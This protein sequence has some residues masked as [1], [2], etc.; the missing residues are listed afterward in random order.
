MINLITSFF[1]YNEENEILKNRNK[2]LTNSLINN[3]NSEFIKKIHLFIENDNVLEIINKLEKKD[4]INIIFFK[5]QPLYSDFFEYSINNLENEI[6]MISNSDI[7]L[8]YCDL[9]CINN[10]SNNI[11]CLTRYEYDLSCPLISNYEG[12]HDAFIFK[13]PLNKEILPYLKHNQNLWGSENVVIDTLIDFG[14]KLFNPC[15]QIKIIHLH[16]TNYRDENRQRIKYGINI[17]PPN[18]Y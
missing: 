15:Y 14:Y 3:L 1:I 18:N 10:I 16:Q 17:I 13:S 7:Y 5:K 12:S 4:K 2:E 9:N 6:C 8:D 11:F